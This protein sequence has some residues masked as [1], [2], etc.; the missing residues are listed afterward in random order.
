MRRA[1]DLSDGSAKI[2]KMVFHEKF[3]AR[4]GGLVFHCARSP[5]KEAEVLDM[6]RGHPGFMQ[7]FWAKDAAGNIVRVVDRIKGGTLA[8][9]VMG[10]GRDHE[11]Y[12]HN[13]FASVL[14][15]FVGLVE[16]IKFLHDRGQKHGDI[17]RDHIIRER[18]SG[19]CRWIDFDISYLHRENMFGYDLFGLGN[20][21]AFLA[22]RGELTVQ[23]LRKS[24]SPAY[25]RLD[26]GDL[27]IVFG[28]RVMNL[29]KVY[30]YIPEALNIILLHFSVGAEV[31]YESTEEFLAD[32]MEAAEKMPGTK[33]RKEETP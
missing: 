25:R 4:V 18:D 5:R 31:F 2:I 33:S 1:L 28:N 7:G 17:R 20:V 29:R 11:D 3:E 15:D 24:G 12:F 21:L 26:E 10:L 23:W 32:L 30:P 6:V 22:G 19:R 8:D 13:H 9:H 27:N 16:A 14:D